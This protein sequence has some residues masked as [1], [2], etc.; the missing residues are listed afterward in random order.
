MK[1]AITAT[2]PHLRAPVDPRFGRCR[3]LVIVD[4]GGGTHEAV[5]NPAVTGPGGAGV[6]LVQE[7]VRRGVGTVITGDV[8]PNAFQALRAA[9]IAVHTGASGTVAEALDAYRR[10]GLRAAEGATVPAHRGQGLPGRGG[11]GTGRGRW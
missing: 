6:A 2:G 9:G 3:Y 11:R 5:E 7:L 4:T 10:G 1:V 8:G